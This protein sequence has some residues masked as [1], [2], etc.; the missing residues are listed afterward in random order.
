MKHVQ[1]GCL[2]RVTN[3]ARSDGSRIENMNRAWNGIARASPCGIEGF[4]NQGHD[5]VLRRNVRVASLP[6]AKGSSIEHFVQHSLYGSHHILLVLEN[7]DIWNNIVK[8]NTSLHLPTLRTAD[9]GESFG[10]LPHVANGVHITAK[11]IDT[12]TIFTQ[13]V[14]VHEEEQSSM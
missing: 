12:A 2:A 11:D 14:T 6:S 13:W 4:H 8:T 3:S 7:V 9:S 10:I 5:L 1:K